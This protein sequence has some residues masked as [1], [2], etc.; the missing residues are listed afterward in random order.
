MSL[1]GKKRAYCTQKHSNRTQKPISNVYKG[2]TFSKMRPPYV[3]KYVLLECAFIWAASTHRNLILIS[4]EKRRC[5]IYI[6]GGCDRRLACSTPQPCFLIA[7][8]DN[9]SR[10][11]SRARQTP[12]ENIIITSGVCVTFN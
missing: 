1:A 12:N 10:G 9:S 5:S 4:Q 7:I 3:E 11:C 6:Y 8:K 2:S